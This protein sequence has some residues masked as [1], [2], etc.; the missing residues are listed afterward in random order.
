LQHHHAQA[1]TCSGS[2]DLRWCSGSPAE[3]VRFSG[4]DDVKRNNICSF[5]RFPCQ[6]DDDE[7][8]PDAYFAEKKKPNYKYTH[9]FGQ[10]SQPPT[11]GTRPHRKVQCASEPARW[12]CDKSHEGGR[13]NGP[14]SLS[15]A[16]RSPR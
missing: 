4:P 3:R 15:S 10:R 16:Q 11:L 5:S 2:H 12:L 14:A 1:G 6:I 8:L 13:P 7:P 9:T